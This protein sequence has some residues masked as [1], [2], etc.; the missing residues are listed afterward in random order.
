MCFWVAALS[1]QYYFLFNA[2]WEGVFTKKWHNIHI[3]TRKLIFGEVSAAAILIAVC[4]IIGKT[5]SVQYVILTIAGIFLYTLNEVIVLEELKVKDIGGAMIIHTFGAFYGIGLTAVYK[6]SKARGSKNLF[7]THDS[8]TSAMV[9]TLFLWCFWP[10]FNAALG[11]SD[12]EIHMSVLNTYFSI[13]GSVLSAYATSMLLGNGRFHMSQ[14]LNATLSG[15]VAM[16]SCADILYDGW[17]AYLVG[18]LVGIISTVCFK[19]SPIFLDKFGIHDV[20]GVFNLH[21]IPGII[22]GFLSAIFRAKYI[23]NKGGNQAAGTVISW[24]IGLFG[25]LIVGLATKCFHNYEGENDFFNDKAVVALEEFVVEELEV[26]G[27]PTKETKYTSS[28]G[29]LSNG[30][31]MMTL[32][33]H[34]AP[35]RRVLDD[36][37][38]RQQQHKNG[39]VLTSHVH[40]E[41][42]R[43]KMPSRH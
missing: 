18:S 5:T 2:L 27:H 32:E 35:D 29:P 7:E 11:T 37:V 36:E 3:N 26:Y 42:E 14:I 15:G 12:A 31:P 28:H 19:Y 22:S 4:A 1:V 6:Y 39:V 38:S 40:L 23:D 43:E 8:L 10:S 34:H 24:A 20:A 33:G 13:I 16:G 9:G 25:G 41:S 30:H 21:G 17:A